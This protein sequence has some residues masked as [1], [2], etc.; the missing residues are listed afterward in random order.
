LKNKQLLEKIREEGLYL[1]I[2][3]VTCLIVFK[4]IFYREDMV[5]II[6]TV[7]SLFYMI[8]LPG[9]FIMIYWIDDIDFKERIVLSVVV[10]T[11]IVGLISYYVGIIG[12]NVKYHVIPIP[13]IVIVISFLLNAKLNK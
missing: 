10:G 1:G 8:L 3:F 6:R 7:F 5:S 13:L 12:L 9:Y 4:V 2:M 11:I